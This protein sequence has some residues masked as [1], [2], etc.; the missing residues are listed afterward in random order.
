MLTTGLHAATFVGVVQ[1]PTIHSEHVYSLV[2]QLMPS[3][4]LI[5]KLGA[6]KIKVTVPSFF[7]CSND[8]ASASRKIADF[9]LGALWA[10]A[11]YRRGARH[12]LPGPLPVGQGGVHQGALVR[13]RRVHEARLRGLRLL[14]GDHPGLP[15][16]VSEEN[17]TGDR[18]D[19]HFGSPMTI[20]VAGHPPVNRRANAAE[21][22]AGS[23]SF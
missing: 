18:K 2:F 13:V 3:L 16:A 6:T 9:A 4:N 11:E 5:F 17:R 10:G 7:V 23:A 8:A 20:I 12:H 14:P 21:I 22:S 15:E 1:L 19:F